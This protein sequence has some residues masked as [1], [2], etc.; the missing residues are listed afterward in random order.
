MAEIKRRV[1]VADAGPLIAFARLD[2]LVL[3]PEMFGTLMV[4]E[5]VLKECL[6]VPTRPDAQV[7]QRA[8]DD[9]MLGVRAEHAS[10]ADYWPPALGAGEQAAIHLAQVL[11][12]PV[13]IDDKLARR[14]ASSVGLRVIG[15]AGVLIQAKQQARIVAIAP[16]LE[17]LQ[18]SG[19]HLAD[20]LVRHM[21]QLA[22]EEE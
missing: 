19:Y 3:L 4:P 14:V 18:D 6:H 21:L 1:V 8:V 12:C 22:G 7:I 11:D 9:G 5:A 13:L 17:T 20:D 10:I 16:L 15:T 2:L